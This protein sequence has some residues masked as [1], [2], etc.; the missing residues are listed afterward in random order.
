MQ[1][2]KLPRKRERRINLSWAGRNKSAGAK[3]PAFSCFQTP[4][5]DARFSL[6]DAQQAA[7]SGDYHSGDYDYVGA[8]AARR[9]ISMVLHG[10]PPTM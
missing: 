3:A 2:S 9:T 7:L 1:R 8:M 4:C 5:H 10:V 6:K